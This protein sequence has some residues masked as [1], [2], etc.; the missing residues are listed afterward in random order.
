RA[1]GYDSRCRHGGGGGGNKAAAGNLWILCIDGFHEKGL[2]PIRRRLRAKI[3][4]ICFW[5]CERSATAQRCVG[6]SSDLSS[7]RART[8]P[9]DRTVALTPLPQPWRVRLDWIRRVVT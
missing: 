1:G 9:I 2:C 4:T 7:S 3:V 6:R 8:M 5:V